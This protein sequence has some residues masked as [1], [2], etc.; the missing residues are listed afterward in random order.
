MT[1]LYAE[2]KNF[3]H[4]DNESLIYKNSPFTGLLKKDSEKEHTESHYQSGKRHGI[5]KSYYLSGAIKEV[6]LYQ[7]GKKS[8]RSIEYWP[9]GTKKMNV[10][11]VDDKMNG[12]YEEWDEASNPT[13]LKRYYMGKVICAKIIF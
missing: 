4:L 9:N 1:A 13:S 11:F 8:G 7:N 3:L 2:V 10:N 6:T 12:V 5:F